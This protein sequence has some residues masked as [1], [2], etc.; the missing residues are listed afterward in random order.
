MRFTLLQTIVVTL[1]P[2]FLLLFPL[3]HSST[4]PLLPSLPSSPNPSPLSLSP[5]SP[6]GLPPLFSLS[7]PFPSLPLPSLF[8]SPSSSFSQDSIVDQSEESQIEAAIRA[9][10][11]EA[12]E[13]DRRGKQQT[14]ID[15]TDD[16]DECVSI[17]SEDSDIEVDFSHGRNTEDIDNGAVKSLQDLSNVNNLTAAMK[18]SAKSELNSDSVW[19]LTRQQMKKRT[20]GIPQGKSEVGDISS[21]EP[22]IQNDSLAQNSGVKL[23]SPFSMDV[24]VSDSGISRKRKYAEEVDEEEGAQLRK[25][26]RG[27]NHREAQTDKVVADDSKR[28]KTEQNRKSEQSQKTERTRRGKG[29]VGAAVKQKGMSTVQVSD[30][31]GNCLSVEEQVASGSVSKDEV[32]QIVI[33]MPNGSRVQKSFICHHPI[34]VRPAF[35]ECKSVLL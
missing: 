25:W 35:S 20:E 27:D 28:L 34:E 31:T 33:R 13:R 16:S 21:L 5:L 14:T 3:S 12:E 2:S 7:S 29:R 11:Q 9:S 22:C 1:P 10:L 6:I 8:L 19:R 32:S 17:S 4:P 24:N 30:G 26:A 23:K 15:L 18:L